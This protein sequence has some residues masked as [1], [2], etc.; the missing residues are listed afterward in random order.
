[1]PNFGEKNVLASGICTPAAGAS[2]ADAVEREHSVLEVIAR[3]P[4]QYR[5]EFVRLHTNEQVEIR[6][7]LAQ[8]WHVDF[9]IPIS[10]S[11]FAVSAY[12][13]RYRSR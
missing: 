10:W 5:R 1:M 4:K 11:A 2:L 8:A 9:P 3:E 7:D 12:R 6:N 13:S